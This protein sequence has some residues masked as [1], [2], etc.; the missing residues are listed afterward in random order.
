MNVQVNYSYFDF[1]IVDAGPGLEGIVDTKIEEVLLPNTPP[2]KASVAY[3]I[4]KKKW[5]AGVA[6]RLVLSHDVTHRHR[7][8]HQV[9]ESQKME[10]AAQVASG[11]AEHFGQLLTAIDHDTALL[12]RKSQD[13]ESFEL[14]NRITATTTRASA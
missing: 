13:S 2:H 4:N 12:V 5:N 8:E 6:A 14:L 10:I 3:S 7:Q 9:R 11:A 1:K